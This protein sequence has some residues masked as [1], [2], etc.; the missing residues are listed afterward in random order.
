MA[1][2][3]AAHRPCRRDLRSDSNGKVANKVSGTSSDVQLPYCIASALMQFAPTNLTE[4]CCR[5]ICAESQILGDAE[6]RKHCKV[7]V[8]DSNA[9]VVSEPGVH[10]GRFHGVTCNVHLTR[11]S[12]DDAAE[13]LDECR[14]AASVA[15]DQGVN[16]PSAYIEVD[17]VE[18]AGA[19]IHL[20][21]TA[22]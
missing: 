13:N 15:P 7:L 3:H 12:L 2:I 1:T 16:L 14:L 4:P 20:R 11:V 10:S 17:T 5:V 8:D 9:E 22:H 21:Y 6:V 18:C 19:R